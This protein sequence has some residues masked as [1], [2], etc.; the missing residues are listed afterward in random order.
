MPDL[1][2]IGSAVIHIDNPII[3]SRM[4]LGLPMIIRTIRCLKKNGVPHIFLCGSDL[5]IVLK[6]VEK[7]GEVVQ[8]GFI[9]H[10]YKLNGSNHYDPDLIQ[11]MVQQKVF[12][13]DFRDV[14]P[15]WW[16]A[17]DETNESVR[18]AEAK[19]FSN[20]RAKTK[21]WIA[22]RLNKPISFWLTRSLV[23]TRIT[24]NQITLGNLFL[25]L[26]GAFF[27][28]Y[29][30]YGVRILGAFMIQ[31][32]SILDGCDGEV[33]R[34]K[35]ETSHQGA[36]LDT[37][38]DD[39]AN[40]AFFVGLY[41]GL[42]LTTTSKIYAVTGLVTFCASLGVTMMIYTQLMKIGEAHAQAFKQASP[43]VE[44]LRP[45]LQ[46]DFFIFVLFIFIALDLRA[47]IFWVGVVST[48]MAFLTYLKSSLARVNSQAASL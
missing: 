12:D 11:W 9:D 43:L 42:F 26:L 1:N 7:Y 17:I 46:R 3:A 13:L 40:N 5:V 29:P 10:G 35:V 38:A 32:S 30:D 14:S 41:W 6:L 25:A 31:I 16:H 18:R 36:W 34:L 48:W 28:A 19:L 2:S 24:P 22:P 44:R 27:I 15:L 8:T 20:I 47:P 33:A 4:V 45:L 37:W 23:R 21:G 39:L